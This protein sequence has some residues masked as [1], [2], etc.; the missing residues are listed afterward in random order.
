MGIPVVGMRDASEPLLACSV[1]DL[2]SNLQ[3]LHPHTLVLQCFIV[4]L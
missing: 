1:P 2:Q 3:P 4:E